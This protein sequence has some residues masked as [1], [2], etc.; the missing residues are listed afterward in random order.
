MPS[1]RYRDV[2]AAI[3]WLCSAFGFMEHDVASEPDGTIRHAQLILGGDMIMLLPAASSPSQSDGTEKQAD[4]SGGLGAQSLYFVVDDAEAHYQRAAAAGA[5]V[6]ENGQFAFG[7]RG[8]SCRDPEGHVWHFGTYNPRG[9]ETTDGL[10][11]RDF[12][13]GSRAADFARGLRDRLSPPVLVAGAAAAVVA[14][15]GIVLD[16]GGAAADERE[17]ARAGA[18]V[19]GQWRPSRTTRMPRARWRGPRR[20]RR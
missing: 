19:P 5:I 10:W 7:G 17:R 20:G 14:I 1:L 4:A 8:Y 12:L 13:Y 16:A 11:M 15:V 3:E 6:L 18:G 2:E 9:E